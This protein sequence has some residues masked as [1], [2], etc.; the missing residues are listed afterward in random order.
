MHLKQ[1][2]R[3]DSLGPAVVKEREKHYSTWVP[4]LV[5]ERNSMAHVMAFG[6]YGMHSAELS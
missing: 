5:K 3:L 2:Y 1:R 4:V 6:N